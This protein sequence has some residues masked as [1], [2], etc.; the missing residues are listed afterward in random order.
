[1]TRIIAEKL[2]FYNFKGSTEE[3][4]VFDPE[5]NFIMGTNGAGKTR[6]LDGFIWNL[7]GKD[8]QGRADFEIKN[9]KD[10]SKNQLDHIVENTIKVDGKRKILTRIYKE[11]RQKVKGA[12][13]PS[14]TGHTTEYV[15]N[16]QDMSAGG[17][18]E[19]VRGIASLDA[20]KM[21]TDPLFFNTDRVGKWDW[22][23]RR[24]ILI[25][26]V[27]EIDAMDILMAAESQ[28]GKL[29]HLRRLIN[30]DLPLES[31][32]VTLRNRFKKLVERFKEI[33]TR[34][35]EA[36]KNRPNETEDDFKDLEGQI[37]KIG[38]LEDDIIVRMSDSNANIESANEE[39]YAKLKEYGVAKRFFDDLVTTAKEKLQRQKR[40]KDEQINEIDTKIS[41][42]YRDVKQK[43][44][45]LE[46]AQKELSNNEKQVAGLR[47]KFQELKGKEFIFDSREYQDKP[48]PVCGTTIKKGHDLKSLEEKAKSDFN[49]EKAVSLDKMRTDATNLSSLSPGLKEK[50][51]TVGEVI[52]QKNTQIEDLQLEK[53][54][55][56]KFEVPSDE[57]IAESVK[58]TP[59]GELAFYEATKLFESLPE[60]P[61]PD[62]LNALKEQRK[63][64][65]IERDDLTK[66]LGLRDEITRIDARIAELEKE[67]KDKA[68]EIADVEK[69]IYEISLFSTTNMEL[70]EERVNGMF[71][72]VHFKLF[73]DQINGGVNQIC[74]M[75]FEGRTWASLNTAD[76]IWAGMQCIKTLQKYYDLYAPI[77]IDNRESTIKI[78]EMDCQVINLVVSE[79][80]RKLTVQPLKS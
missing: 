45:E 77:F 29:E 23:N 6:I 39:Y 25:K 67:E 55:I 10:T 8:G 21:V 38:E 74:T 63:A 18:E 35:E 27:G 32:L 40:G 69:Q 3:E 79:K 58:E 70:V 33:P 64:L 51:Q 36:F 68:Q 9:S 78:P 4:I 53:K 42:L 41:S 22:K 2:K 60:K 13:T 26:M 19:Y 62:D 72:D 71:E 7:A 17:Y 30:E 12:E 75:W 34:I 57:S 50:I 31:E 66:K 73:E 11:K 24:D 16:G 61:K 46:L 47:S 49:H 54:G 44:M 65:T 15:V 28:H 59:E 1:M 20:L 48:C 56:D 80:H 43:S 14:V 5:G 76:K 52:A 37:E